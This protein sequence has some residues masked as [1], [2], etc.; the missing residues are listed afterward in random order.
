MN[1]S[2]CLDWLSFTRTSTRRTQH[3]P[4]PL[5]DPVT[6]G[7][8]DI[9][10][11]GYR[12]AIRYPSG[13]ITMYDGS[14]PSMGVHFIYSGSALAAIGQ[15]RNDGGLSVLREHVERGDKCTRIDLAIDVREGETILRELK[16]A[17]RQAEFVGTARKLSIIENTTDDGFTIYAGSRQSERF[18]RIYNKAAQLREDGLWTRVEAEVKGDS[19]RAVSRAILGAGDGGLCLVAKSVIRRVVDFDCPSWKAVMEGETLPVGT[20]K[21]TDKQTETW[22]LGQVAK[23]VVRYDLLN[24][25]KR[26]VER[27]FDTIQAL[28]EGYEGVADGDM[29]EM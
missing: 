24:P 20:P 11:F 10:R 19:A 22:I 6:S 16:Q 25:E 5:F 14:T 28:I 15:T 18:V 9:P 17:T 3:C 27:L 7:K 26:I 1:G 29:R 12:K 23:A 4:L 8:G 21:A 2:V 13:A